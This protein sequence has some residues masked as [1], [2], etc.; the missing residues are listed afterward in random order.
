MSDVFFSNFSIG[1][2]NL[3]GCEAPE[4]YTELR[5]TRQ[6]TTDAALTEFDSGSTEWDSGSTRWDVV[7][8]VNMHAN[9]GVFWT[10]DKCVGSKRGYRLS[11][12]T[13][14]YTVSG[15]EATKL[16]DT[17]LSLNS[18]SFTLNGEEAYRI[19]G[20]ISEA[21]SFQSTGESASYGLSKAVESGS[22]QS[23]GLDVILDWDRY[24][25]ITHATGT[26]TY[27]GIDAEEY[28]HFNHKVDSGAFTLDGKSAG[29][30]VDRVLTSETG[31]FNLSGQDAE[32]D[33]DNVFTLTAEAGSLVLTG[34]DSVYGVAKSSVAGSFL[35]AGQDADLSATE[36]IVE[37]SDSGSFLVN[38]SLVGSNSSK[39]LSAQSAAFTLTGQDSSEDLSEY[40]E[41]GEFTSQGQKANKRL[42]RYSYQDDGFLVGATA[43]TVKISSRS[44]PGA[45]NYE[46]V[47][48]HR[49]FK[50]QALSA[51]YE[52]DFQYFSLGK[53]ISYKAE[54]T[55]FITEGKDASLRRS[56][57]LNA[58]TGEFDLSDPPKTGTHWKFR[59][60][61]AASYKLEGPDTRL[62]DEQ[63]NTHFFM[64]G[65]PYRVELQKVSYYYRD[66]SNPPI[67]MTGKFTV[68]TS[69][70]GAEIYKDGIYDNGEVT[71]EEN[72][73]TA[74]EPFVVSGMDV[75]F[76]SSDES[77]V[78]P[79]GRHLCLVA[80]TGSMLVDEDGT[81]LNRDYFL[82]IPDYEVL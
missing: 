76:Y 9:R 20:Y 71:P 26:F 3:N 49:L 79:L 64:E 34:E 38:T 15:Q 74:G 18:S 29:L 52:L 19:K 27:N 57:N 16:Q 5:V 73:L 10:R 40:Y 51:S 17:N 35:L 77:T 11:T 63:R 6:D 45:F 50:L 36:D 66:D 4:G 46:G 75:G 33:E 25:V 54:V 30:V 32:L 60:P 59:I 67:D 48:A 22:I 58:G 23:T 39:L 68:L 56:N 37:P 8:W 82:E 44:D 65:S 41:T 7:P 72:V 81:K 28:R 31:D 13:G 47:N 62:I 55:P 61:N 80:D 14:E 69:D 70:V 2:F 24:I 43:T 12:D 1:Q 53:V 78:Q 42:A 21:G